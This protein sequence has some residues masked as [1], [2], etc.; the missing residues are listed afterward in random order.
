M[1]PGV[2]LAGV[3]A[4]ETSNSWVYYDRQRNWGGGWEVSFG[5]KEYLD[6][7]KIDLDET[8]IITVQN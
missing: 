7:L 6:C 8:K 3:K 5:S 4:S 1:I 2:D